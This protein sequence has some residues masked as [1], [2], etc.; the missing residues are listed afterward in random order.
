MLIIF[1]VAE[2]YNWFFSQVTIKISWIFSCFILKLLCNTRNLCY[3]F[4]C[5]QTGF[6]FL[7]TYCRI[8]I[9]TPCN[10]WWWLASSKFCILFFLVHSKLSF[11]QKFSQLLKIFNRLSIF[12]IFHSLGSNVTLK[13]QHSYLSCITTYLISHL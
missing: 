1:L 5:F 9:S 3:N 11:F 12:F 8:I 2:K 7:M 4:S 6:V 10:H 13:M